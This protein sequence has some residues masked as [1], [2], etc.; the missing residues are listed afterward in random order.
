MLQIKGKNYQPHVGEFTGFL[1]TINQVL[2]RQGA[3]PAPASTAG[4]CG[5]SHPLPCLVPGAKMNDENK[6]GWGV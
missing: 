1:I 2:G 3:M 4:G 6:G 5:P